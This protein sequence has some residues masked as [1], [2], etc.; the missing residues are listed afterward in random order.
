MRHLPTPAQLNSAYAREAACEEAEEAHEGLCE[1]VRRT[2]QVG[3]STAEAD[4]A[5]RALRASLV[6]QPVTV[7]V[8]SVGKDKE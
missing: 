2:S 4:A 1:A 7:V 5:I 6:Q 3:V 8:K